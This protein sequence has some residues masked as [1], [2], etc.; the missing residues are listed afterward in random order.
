MATDP[1]DGTHHVADGLEQLVEGLAGGKLLPP[2][3]ES[4]FS[5]GQ[6]AA[7]YSML[8]IMATAVPVQ[9]KSADPNSFG[10]C[11]AGSIEMHFLKVFRTAIP[12]VCGNDVLERA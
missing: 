1:F 4:T 5:L 9:A 3:L 7:A 2:R 10:E 8:V 11:G 12:L 6:E